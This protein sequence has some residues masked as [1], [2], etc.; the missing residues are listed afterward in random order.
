MSDL[1]RLLQYVKPHRLRFS[2]AVVMMIGVGFFEAIAALLIGPIFDRVL[3]PQAR[4]SSV[5][6]LTVPYVHN[7]IYLHLLVPHW[8]H[9][10]WTVVAVFIL[11][12]T[13]GKATCRYLPNYLLNFVGFSIIM[14]LRNKLYERIIHQAM[15]F[16]HRHPPG[17]LMS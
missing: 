1:R 13:L 4:D 10:R 17:R 9:H 14:E 16:F 3:N 11:S 6:L 5:V 8:I 2:G 7:T 15:S 12:V